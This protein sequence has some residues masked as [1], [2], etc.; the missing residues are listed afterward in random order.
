GRGLRPRG[1]G[2]GGRAGRGRAGTLL[3]RGEL[4]HGPDPAAGRG[5][6]LPVRDRP[7]APLHLAEPGRRARPRGHR[8][9]R[10]STDHRTRPTLMGAGNHLLPDLPGPFRPRRRLAR[11]PGRA[12]RLGNSPTLGRRAPGIGPEAATEYYGG[13]LD[14]VRR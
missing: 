14:G 9:R 5:H 10:L 2:R 3:E 4:V 11:A 8:R 12:P 1:R 13:T 7:R 6:P